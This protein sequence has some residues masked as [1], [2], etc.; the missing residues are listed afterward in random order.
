MILV[1]RAAEI[2]PELGPGPRP[3]ITQS[4]RDLGVEY[5]L[6]ATVD[7]VGERSVTLSSGEVLPTATTIWTAG[8]TASPLAALVSGERDRLGRLIVDFTCGSR[9]L[10]R[11]SR[12]VTPRQPRPKWDM[13]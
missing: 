3:H 7:S 6:E 1:E 11:S 2:G 4:L 5:R 12:P 8:M 13:P 9:E 10:P